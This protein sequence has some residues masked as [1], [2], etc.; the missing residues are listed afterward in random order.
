M[1]VF[2]D[3]KARHSSKHIGIFRY[4]SSHIF[5]LIHSQPVDVEDTVFWNWQVRCWRIQ[6][7]TQE[8]QG[9]PG[10]VR[11][12]VGPRVFSTPKRGGFLRKNFRKVWNL[13]YPFCF[14]C[15]VWINV[16]GAVYNEILH[17]K[18]GESGEEV[19]TA[20]HQKYL[21]GRPFQQ[22]HEL[23]LQEFYWAGGWGSDV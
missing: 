11:K 7:S 15:W 14:P 23:Y 1:S 18:T 17:L 8:E 5:R 9:H 3:Y 12:W 21:G 10:G 20:H 16:P 22:I 6:E 13:A 19:P 2:L 4:V